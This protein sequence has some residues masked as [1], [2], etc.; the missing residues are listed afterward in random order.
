MVSH[1]LLHEGVFYL[2]GATR[3]QHDWFLIPVDRESEITVGNAW[4]EPSLLAVKCATLPALHRPLG[5]F[6]VLETL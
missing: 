5:S 6:L 3:K 2:H 1:S 4:F